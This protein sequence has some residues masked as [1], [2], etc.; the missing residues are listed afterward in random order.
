MVCWWLPGSYLAADN[1]HQSSASATLD[2]EPTQHRS[3]SPRFRASRIQ[4]FSGPDIGLSPL[5]PR[6]R[7]GFRDSSFADRQ[8]SR[9]RSLLFNLK[10]E[11]VDMWSGSAER[12][13]ADEMVFASIDL[14]APKRYNLD[15]LI[16]T[17]TYHSG[18]MYRIFIIV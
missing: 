13:H 4:G 3:A 9:A 18:R 12:R 1:T 15:G 17:D 10:R 14:A 6:L 16:W 7:G 8:R 11:P 5:P 2:H